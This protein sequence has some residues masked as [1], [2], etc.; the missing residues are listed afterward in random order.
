MDSPGFQ[1]QQL[2]QHASIINDPSIVDEKDVILA[3]QESHEYYSESDDSVDFN[4]VQQKS[5]SAKKKTLP[6]KSKIKTEPKTPGRSDHPIENVQLVQVVQD[7]VVVSYFKWAT[8]RDVV[9]GYM[10]DIQA[11]LASQVSRY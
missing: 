1:Q 8:I 5:K 9:S 10:M 3:A 6:K 7:P 2:L 4:P 11:F